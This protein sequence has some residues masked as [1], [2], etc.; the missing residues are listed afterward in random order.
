MKYDPIYKHQDQLNQ[1]EF[2]NLIVNSLEESIKTKHI[3]WDEQTRGTV[4][5][6]M[7]KFSQPGIFPEQEFLQLASIFLNRKFVLYPVNPHY[8]TNG[9]LPNKI[10]IFPHKDCEC[11][12]KTPE[13][14]QPFTMLYYEETNF[15][16][17][18]YQSIRP[19]KSKN[20]NNNN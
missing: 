3:S 19:L 4:Q 16:D 12:Q 2:R 6:W 13:E 9:G 15:V 5:D 11:G 17:P 8:N 18:H 20:I 10:E 14:V 1:F 7:E